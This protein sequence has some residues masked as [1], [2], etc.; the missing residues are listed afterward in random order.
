MTETR[1]VELWGGASDGLQVRV[2]EET[3]EVRVPVHHPDD[4]DN[5]VRLRY[6]KDTDGTFRFK[7]VIG[8]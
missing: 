4:P 2:H 6:L 7:G 8:A 1:W 5:G 3:E